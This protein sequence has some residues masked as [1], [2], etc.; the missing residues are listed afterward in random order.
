MG[1][2]SVDRHYFQRDAVEDIKYVSEARC[3]ATQL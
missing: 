2:K 3:G 1:F